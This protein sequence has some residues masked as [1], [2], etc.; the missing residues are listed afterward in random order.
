MRGSERA[1]RLCV[2]S[3]RCRVSWMPG[4]RPR[5]WRCWGRP[6]R[7]RRG[8][9]RSR[10]HPRAQDVD[11]HGQPRQQPRWISRAPRRSMPYCARSTRRATHWLPPM[12]MRARSP[13]DGQLAAERP[14]ILASDFEAGKR[15]QMKGEFPFPRRRLGE[16]A[17][18]RG[19]VVTRASNSWRRAVG[20]LWAV[21]PLG[22][23]ATRRRGRQPAL[24]AKHLR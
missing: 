9:T 19:H 8:G 4:R 7:G 10:C 16:V 6:R 24:V 5:T 2:Q 22:S 20:S 13:K 1:Q 17:R 12:C 14:R 3:L 21:W 11:I 15:P 18:E 23:G